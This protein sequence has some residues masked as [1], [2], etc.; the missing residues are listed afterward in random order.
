MM[1]RRLSLLEEVD[2]TFVFHAVPQHGDG[3]AENK[4]GRHKCQSD[5]PIDT[6]CV[7]V[8]GSE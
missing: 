3:A 4:E 5:S 1:Q 2:Q 6:V 8:C 7:C